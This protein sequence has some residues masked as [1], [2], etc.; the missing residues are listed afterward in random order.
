MS[1]RDWLETS[2]GIKLEMELGI[3]PKK[4]EKFR[5]IAV[6]CHPHPGFGGDMHNPVVR[7]L[8][9]AA[10]EEG[11]VPLLFNFRGTGRSE[12]TQSGGLKEIE[13]VDAAMTY[14][15]KLSADGKV[16]LMGYS[17]GAKMATM[18]LNSGKKASAFV[19]V[20]VPSTTDYP[21]YKDIP[22]LYITGEFDDV[23]PLDDG[24]SRSLMTGGLHVVV[25]GSDHFFNRGRDEIQEAVQGFIGITCPVGEDG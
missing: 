11:F 22:S 23:G 10:W 12:G 3:E 17:F 24:L 15:K 1:K 2:D 16:L 4:G 9:S 18:W 6:I 19:G 21:D 13:D 5:G 20:A 7:S 25:E 8:A 14:A